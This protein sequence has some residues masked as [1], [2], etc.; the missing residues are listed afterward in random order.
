[1][2]TANKNQMARNLGRFIGSYRLEIAISGFVI[3]LFLSAGITPMVAPTWVSILLWAPIVSL[4]VWER[5]FLAKHARK[6]LYASK[7]RRKVQAAARDA[8]FGDLHVDNVTPTLPGE[9]VDVQVPRGATVSALARNSEAMAACLRVSDLRVIAGQDKSRARIAVIRRNPLLDMD[10]QAWPLVG[11][12][13]VNVR[14]GIPFGLDEYGNV[15]NARLLSRNIIMGG[16]PDAGKSTALRIITAAGALDPKVKLWM[17]DGKTEGAEFVHWASAAHRLIRGRKLEEAVEMFAELEQR[18]EDRGR[19]IVSR[20]KVFV[21]DDMELDLLIIDELPQFM[22]AFET[23]TKAEQSMVKT[24]RSSIWKLIAVGR[25]TGMITV[26]SA[27]KPTADIVPS[28]SRDLIDHKFALHCN[29]RAMSDA[30]LGAGAGEEAPANA[31]DIPSGQPGLGYYV[32]DNGTVKMRNFFISH[33]QAKEIASRV[34]SRQLDDE[35]S[36]LSA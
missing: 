29:T 11:A 32:G 4:L 26:L 36:T 19:D 9:W 35:L 27:Q 10:H 34:S 8:G 3:L 7:V 14:E 21:C 15:V 17:M 25:W 30:I 13:K 2:S 20:G 28:E 24:I 23:D 6:T 33:D 1:M 22:R 18:V 12:E 5:G 16:A 31:A